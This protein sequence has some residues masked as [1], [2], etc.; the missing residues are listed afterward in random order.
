MTIFYY[1]CDCI[2]TA[3]RA[4][5]ALQLADAIFE[6][7]LTR[8]RIYI[9]QAFIIAF[10]AIVQFANSYLSHSI[11]SNAILFVTIFIVSIASLILYECTLWRTVCLNIL[12]WVSLALIDFFIQIC[13]W[14]I[15]EKVDAKKDTLISVSIYRGFYLLICILLL[16]PIGVSLRK[17][18]NNKK[19]RISGFWKQASIIALFLLPCM[20]Y[21]QRIYLQMDSEKLFRRWW[22]FFMGA[23]LIFLAFGF[24]MLKQK[25]EDEKRMY[26]FE[27]Q[28]LEN[29]YEGV[30]KNYREK[31]ILMHD[32]KNHLR[33]LHSM[34]DE[35]PKE[36]CQAY[37][38]SLTGEIQ[39]KWNAVWTN[40]KVLDLVLNMKFQEAEEAQIKVWCQS[41]DLSE[42]K[43][44]S[45]EICALF[46]NLLDNVVE[47]NEN[48]S[49]EIE[50]KIEIICRRQG[51]ILVISISNSAEDG[52]ESSK[53]MFSETTKQDKAFHGFG[54]FSIEN[55][56]HNHCG[57]LEVKIQ[58]NMVK[59]LIYLNGFEE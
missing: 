32:V 52:M 19:T 54:M 25:M 1:L 24:S 41:D 21:F 17:W 35:R 2:N 29:S 23:A 46:A 53:R 20:I 31:A 39:K 37:I 40:H 16:I 50:R 5:L 42:L 27:V 18:F 8:K 22:I 14:L 38:M 13:G 48:C 12:S 57:H 30:L 11:F 44:D 10:I 9:G 49:E 43:L 45:V 59:I 28:M 26:Q 58:E 3:V 51:S 15:L 47:A 4:W 55:I 6:P 33:T 56:I 36:E 7:K 34:L